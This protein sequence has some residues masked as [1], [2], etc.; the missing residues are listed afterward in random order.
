MPDIRL[1]QVSKRFGD[2]LVID[3][4]S[5]DIERGAFY[6]LLGPS[7]CGKTTTLRMIGG[8]EL[9]TSGRVLL[10]GEDVTDCPPHKRDVNTV[11]QSYALFPHLTVERNV[12]FGLERQGVGK[13][14]V[15]KRVGEALE[16]VQL[17][18][19]AKRKPGSLSGGQAQRVAL[20]RA[21][22]NRPRALLLDE[23]LGALDLRLRRQLQLELKRI[24]QEVGITFI[25]VTHDQE[26]AMSM[27]DTIAV[28][29]RGQI[30]QAGSATE[31]YERPQTAF[32][33][34]FLGVSNLVRGT[35]GTM[36]G[37]LTPVT[38][39][40]GAALH[41]P[42]NRCIDHAG[43]AVS[44]GV[45]PEK[46]KLTPA[47]TAVA[48]GANVLRGRIVLSSFLG[49]SLQYIIKTVGGEELMVIAQNEDGSLPDSLGAGQE[50]QLAWDP[51]HTFV[52][53]AEDGA[54]G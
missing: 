31:L 45:R 15:R 12:A 2:V 38:T 43:S 29:N 40:D 24:Q 47:G 48:D 26:E 7:G 41:A 18:H 52:V 4:L 20:A 44:I 54:D 13:A 14:E 3:T 42:S 32:V 28:M 9:P 36:N 27:A 16:T 35:V 5:L 46:V 22:V 23:P 39:H 37:D 11:F 30:E 25:H 10:G 51:R 19:L 1:E 50:V 33:A 21:L 34:R 8:F 6:A 17:P 53:A 49:V